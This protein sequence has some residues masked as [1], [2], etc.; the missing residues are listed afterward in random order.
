MRISITREVEIPDRLKIERY[1]RTPELGP[2]ILFFS[3]GSALRD[4][5]KEL[6][7]YTHNSI[8][9]ITP[10]DSGGSSAVIRNAFCMPAVGDIRNRLMSLADQSV[11]GNPEIFDLFVHRLS[12]HAK[13]EEL[14]RELEIMASGKHELVARIT[15]P[16]RKIIRNHFH[17]FLEAMPADFDLRGASIGN[18]V[19]TAGYLANRRQ[20][21]PVI[22]IF[23]KL[24]Q[25]CGTVRPVVN[26]DMHLAA[27]LRD[28]TVVV[29]QHRMTGKEEEPLE[30]PIE[31]LWLTESLENVEPVQVF[32]RDKIRKRIAEAELICYPIGSFYSSVVANLLPQGVGKAVAENSC[33]KIFVPNTGHDPESIGLSVEQQVLRLQHHLV[34]SGAPE[35]SDVL[36]HVVVDSEHGDYRGG[37]DMNVI[38]AHGVEVID[39]RLVSEESAQYTDRT[40]LAEVLLSLT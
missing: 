40:L 30:S 39:C 38:R 18:L 29:G 17:Q 21:D 25:V 31:D 24:V 16:M 2:R 22:Y 7:N 19:L 4:V 37:M 11:K 28:G 35:E 33:P 13:Q 10:F 27:R 14:Y 26:K 36:G 5:S 3:G 23:S 1:R 32:I 6:I 9:L 20:L 34:Q 15:D 12:K 8:H